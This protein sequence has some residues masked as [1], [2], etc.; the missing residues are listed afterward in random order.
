VSEFCQACCHGCYALFC[1]TPSRNWS[2]H[3]PK[4]IQKCGDLSSACKTVSWVTDVKESGVVTVGLTVEAKSWSV[5]LRTDVQQTAVKCPANIMSDASV[6]TETEVLFMSK[7]G[8][9]SVGTWRR[10]TRDRDGD[11]D[12]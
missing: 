5:P 9:L 8:N 7:F 1:K 2:I 11:R 10:G 12:W 3:D 4:D 6:T